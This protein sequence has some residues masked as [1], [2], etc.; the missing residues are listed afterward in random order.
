MFWHLSGDHPD[1]SVFSAVKRWSL[2]HHNHHTNGHWSLVAPCANSLTSKQWVEATHPI[3][4][5][6][7]SYNDTIWACIDGSGWTGC[8]VSPPEVF[9]TF[10]ALATMG[11]L[12]TC[13][14][15]KTKIFV[16]RLNACPYL[17]LKFLT[18]TM[19][20]GRL[21]RWIT[22]PKPKVH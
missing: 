12:V 17:G 4:A 6:C 16:S 11:W 5:E 14:V 22:W 21:S 19:M 13:Q 18:T 10:Q 15:G 9:P 2:P 3:H 20:M 1:I 7:K 8:W